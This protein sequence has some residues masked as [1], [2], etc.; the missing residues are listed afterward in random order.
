MDIGRA[1]LTVLVLA[2]IAAALAFFSLQSSPGT[3][4][5]SGYVSFNSEKLKLGASSEAAE[6]GGRAPDFTLLSTDGQTISLSQFKGQTILINFWAS[7]CVPCRTEMPDLEEAFR[8][9]GAQ[10]LQV[11]AVNLQEAQG[12]ARNFATRYGLTFPILLDQD[13]TVGRSYRLT[14]LPESWLV[15][16][17]GIL[18]EHKIGAFSKAELEGLLDTWLTENSAQR[19]EV[20]P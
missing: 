11:L 17:S 18:R 16:S 10:G 6:L 3:Q 13:G 9:K 14:G 20:D 19:P 12:P 4:E 2:A 7:W 15:D 5:T 1:G 8:D